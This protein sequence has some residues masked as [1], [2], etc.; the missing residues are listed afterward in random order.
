MKS[1]QRVIFHID[2]NCYFASVSQQDTPELRGKPVAVMGK[3]KGTVV[4]AASK[5]AKKVGIK[6]GT[7]KREAILLYPNIIC[8][9]PNFAAY[10]R[11]TGVILEVLNEFS[12][13][14]EPFSIDEAFLDLT[15]TYYVK[16]GLHPTEIAQKIKL[17]LREKLGDIITCS[18]GIADNKL[19]AKFGSDLQKPDGLV[20]LT[21]KQYIE[22]L[23]KAELSDICGIGSNIVRHLSNL[24]INTMRDLR[25]TQYSKL[26]KEFGRVTGRF[27]YLASR[28]LDYRKVDPTKYLSTPKSVSNGETFTEN[29]YGE[30]L[31]SDIY[32]LCEKVS[33]R[34][35]KKEL[36][37]KVVIIHIKDNNFKSYE[38]SVKL[39]EFT[40][41]TQ[42][43]F[44]ALA[45][46]ISPYFISRYVCVYA[47]ELS[48]IR[49]M[50]IFSNSDKQDKLQKA[51]DKV[52]EKYGRFTI[53]PSSVHRPDDL[54]ENN[55]D[56][57]FSGFDQDAK[58]GID[59]T[60]ILRKDM[61]ILKHR[62]QGN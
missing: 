34:L 36:Y 61:N 4:I 19:M 7:T 16:L 46:N 60:T 17:R 45:S 14:I 8:V 47:H 33:L 11:T 25:E 31:L 48:N 50:D 6:T 41:N 49:I 21:P 32:K 5:E 38:Y 15:D 13:V 27:L 51:I 52:N 26:R 40:N 18:I 22:V 35:R 56:I 1:L 37:T 9:E 58:T 62:I 43:I 55:V 30:D 57:P 12:P 3:G 20:Y 24:R 23:D 39:H 53:L 2:M 54:G 44:N 42:N 10:I 59:L 28:G 29:K